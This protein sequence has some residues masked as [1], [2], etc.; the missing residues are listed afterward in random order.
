MLQLSNGMAKKKTGESADGETSA[1][2]ITYPVGYL[3]TSAKGFFNCKPFEVR[4]ALRGRD[5]WT[6]DEAKAAVKK[7]LTGSN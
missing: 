6:M 7:L 5:K 2:G 3:I 4:A 1:T